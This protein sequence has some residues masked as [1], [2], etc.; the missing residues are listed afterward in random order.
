MAVNGEAIYGTHPI[1][2]YASANICLTQSK[3]SLNTYAFYLGDPANPDITLPAEIA[4]DRFAPAKD[5]KVTLLGTKTK[6]KW[7]EDGKNMVI[8]IPPALLNKPVGQHAVAFLI[9]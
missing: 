5:S 8:T 7:R 3:D 6:L 1:R 2:P 4:I 9:K